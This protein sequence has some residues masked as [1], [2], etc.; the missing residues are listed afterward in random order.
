M[1]ITNILNFFYYHLSS[2]IK[3]Y[4]FSTS[5]FSRTWGECEK[6]SFD[7][8]TLISLYVGRSDSKH[9]RNLHFPSVEDPETEKIMMAKV[10]KAHMKLSSPL[11]IRL[12]LLIFKQPVSPFAGDEIWNF[13]DGISKVL[14][15]RTITLKSAQENLL[16]CGQEF[17]F[18]RTL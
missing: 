15:V 5:E 2:S 1:E 10:L 16:I 3:L 18:D 14:T 9:N 17:V 8:K 11:I 13:D 7:M 4:F 12:G 6:I